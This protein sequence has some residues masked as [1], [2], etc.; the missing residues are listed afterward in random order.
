MF[1]LIRQARPSRGLAR[2]CTFPPTYARRRPHQNYR[3]SRPPLRGPPTY[4]NSSLLAVSA[5]TRRFVRQKPTKNTSREHCSLPRLP[6]ELIITRPLI[7]I[8]LPRP[9]ILPLPLVLTAVRLPRARKD[10]YTRLI[11]SSSSRV[12]DFLASHLFFQPHIQ[13]LPS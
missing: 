4:P 8:P 10:G 1:S 13:Q 3:H 5:G 11:F 9:I 7:V 12:E 2:V 6:R